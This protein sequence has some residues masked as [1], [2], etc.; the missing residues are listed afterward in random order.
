MRVRVSPPVP[1][2]FIYGDILPEMPEGF[3]APEDW[4]EHGTVGDPA[5]ICVR[6]EVGVAPKGIRWAFGPICFEEYTSDTEPDLVESEKG[7]LPRPRTIMWH[8]VQRSDVPKGWYAFSKHPWRIDGVLDLEANSDYTALW[9]KNARRDLRL[10]KEQFAPSYRIEKT[11]LD[12]YAAAYRTSLIAKRV[13]LERLYQLE[14]RMNTSA[15][16]HIELWIVR[17]QSGVVIAGTAIIYSPTYKHSTHLAPFITAEGRSAYAATALI[18]HWFE[19][20]RARGYRFAVT[21]NFWFQGQPKDW[22]GFSEFKSH[23]GFSYVA[24]PPTLYRFKGG[25]FF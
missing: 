9:H 1:M 16:E 17:N 24:Y 11:S 20:T 7:A 15:R 25:K 19:E 8:R 23:F 14:R 5:S 3:M 13:D 18:E 4:P 10:W 12:E 2:Q 6:E 22:R 21:T